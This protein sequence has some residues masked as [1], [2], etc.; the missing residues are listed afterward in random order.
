MGS[1]VVYLDSCA[2]DVFL[3]RNGYFYERVFEVEV[4]KT[5]VHRP[6]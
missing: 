2:G 3:D 5:F 1:L 4:N 6:S